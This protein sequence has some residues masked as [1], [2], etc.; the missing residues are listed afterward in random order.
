MCSV[1]A[2]G[3]K[4]ITPRF[5]KSF[6]VFLVRDNCAF[7]CFS[8]GYVWFRLLS[9]CN[10][11]SCFFWERVRGIVTRFIRRNASFF[12]LAADAVPGLKSSSGP[13]HFAGCRVSPVVLT[14]AACPCKTNFVRGEQRRGSIWFLQTRPFKLSHTHSEHTCT[15]IHTHYLGCFS[16]GWRNVID[17][18]R[19]S[20]PARPVHTQGRAHSGLDNVIQLA[21]KQQ[22][23]HTTGNSLSNFTFIFW[24]CGSFALRSQSFPPLAVTYPPCL[25]S[26]V[27]VHTSLC[28]STLLQIHPRLLNPHSTKCI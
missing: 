9:K 5:T 18:P 21:W 27:T 23:T 19:G 28:F 12:A 20:E 8:C 15:D 6:T 10:F 1:W 17:Q 11:S 3:T 2:C 4:H 24:L 26:A 13:G 16:A 22:H 25:L 14:S 7:G